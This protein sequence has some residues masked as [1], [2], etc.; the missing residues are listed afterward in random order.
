MRHDCTSCDPGVLACPTAFFEELDRQ[1]ML[2]PGPDLVVVTRIDTGE[3]LGA[4]DL[5]GDLEADFMGE[6][7]AEAARSAGAE[8]RDLGSRRRVKA[9]HLVRRRLGRTVPRP[10]DMDGWTSWLNSSNLTDAYLGEW[11]LVTEHGWRSLLTHS[12]LTHSGPAGT[13]ARLTLLA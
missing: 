4:A 9:A 6:A 13:S 12:L 7:I 10:H 2:V 3:I 11:Y 5:P 8:P 1:R